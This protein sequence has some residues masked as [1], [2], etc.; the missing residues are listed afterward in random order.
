MFF[1][2]S[3]RRRHTRLVSDW[4]SDVC[5][6]DLV[7]APLK[8]PAMVRARPPRDLGGRQDGGAHHVAEQGVVLRSE[9]RR[10]G[11]DSSGG[12]RDKRYAINELTARWPTTTAGKGPPVTTEMAR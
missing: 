5:S 8:H 7:H 9:E 2:F 3:S 12:W 11:K 4:S 1:F 6:S 10:A